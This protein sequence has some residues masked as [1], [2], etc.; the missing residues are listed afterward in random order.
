MKLPFV[1]V[2][3]EVKTEVASFML[4]TYV[5]LIAETN[6]LAPADKVIAWE[7]EIG[8][9]AEVGAMPFEK[10]LKLTG[11]ARDAYYGS[12]D[13]LKRRNTTAKA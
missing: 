5:H 2:D 6:I 9:L 7:K 1:I 13:E 8:T 12:I 11:K 3:G 4:A 10:Y